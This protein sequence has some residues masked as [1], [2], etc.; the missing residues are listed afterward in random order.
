MS[1]ILL[2]RRAAEPELMDDYA[3]S[4]GEALREAHR[5]LRRLN[6]LFAASGPIVFGVERLWRKA[7]C[8][9]RLSVLDIGCGQGDVNGALLRWAER[10][11]VVLQLTLADITE[12]A[13]AEARALYQEEPRVKVERLDLFELPDHYADITV[14]SQVLHHFEE[15]QAVQALNAMAR[16]ARM[17]CVVGDI[18]RHP[19]AWAAV[20]LAAR[21]V[22]RNRYIR[23]DGPLSVAKGFRA[24]DWRCFR[25]RLQAVDP[26][27]HLEFVWRP[28]F[29]YCCLVYRA[30]GG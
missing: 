3:S 4:G 8:P 28:L 26:A 20:W 25:N 6:L 29:R 22:S 10:R 14:A 7:G 9:D 11:G 5:H 1:D 12:E 21:M 16:S 18:H 30:D 13:C 27:Y 24:S 23:H 15:D 2:R 17:G 19:A